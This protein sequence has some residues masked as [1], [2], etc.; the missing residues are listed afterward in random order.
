MANKRIINPIIVKQS[1][2]KMAVRVAKGKYAEI[3]GSTGYTKSDRRATNKAE[4]QVSAL[5]QAPLWQGN[6]LT[7]QSDIVRLSTGEMLVSTQIASGNTG[8][9]EPVVAS[10]AAPAAIVDGAVTWWPLSHSTRTPPVGALAVEVTDSA[11]GSPL[12]LFNMSGSS[13]LFEQVSAPNNDTIAGAGTTLRHRAW[14]FNDGSLLDYGF[15]AN[16]RVGKIRTNAFITMSDVIDIGYFSTSANFL[17]ERILIQ[18][19]GFQLTEAPIKPAAFGSSR[20]KRLRIPGGNRKRLVRIYS[21]G[22]FGLS[23]I[24]VRPD[25]TIEKPPERALTIW[26]GWDSINDTERP[27]LASAHY[28]LSVRVARRLGY[29]NCVSVGAGGVSYSGNDAVSGRKAMDTIMQLND[30]TP[31]KPDAW[32]FGL[33]YNAGGSGWSPV[34][35]ADKGITCW[36]RARTITPDSPILIK[37][38]WY[39]KPGVEASMTAVRDALK[40][41]F[42]EW[43]DPNSAFIDPIDGSI[44][45]GDGYVI[46]AASGPW[47]TAAM[48]AWAL[49]ALDA[50]FDGAHPSIAGVRLL[51]D[52]NCS[53]MDMALIAL[54]Y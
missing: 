37:G 5:A 53:A 42:L 2:G 45:R 34:L 23:Y 9:V 22:A 6:T 10:G 49:P 1:S 24:G 11:G 39:L 38:P 8:N 46:K 52:C 50:I 21:S 18:V 14:T 26:M 40:A 16:G 28:D 19:Q 29:P 32:S 12:S 41:K 25:C 43:K 30:F 4:F 54:G 31:F 7:D 15:G 35:E 13:Q 47:I 51:E 33:G 20:Y 3:D 27:N 36:K 44:T 48:A 17:N